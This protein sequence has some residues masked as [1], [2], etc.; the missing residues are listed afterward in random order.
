MIKTTEEVLRIGTKVR[1]TVTITYMSTDQSFMVD[2]LTYFSFQ[3]VLYDCCNK[4]RL[5]DDAY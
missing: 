3:P 1:F 2:P 4:G 5:W